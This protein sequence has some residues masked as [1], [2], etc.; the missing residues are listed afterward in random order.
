MGILEDIL[1]RHEERL[2]ITTRALLFMYFK[3]QQKEAGKTP[4]SWRPYSGVI[5]TPTTQQL[6]PLNMRRD[7]FSIVNLGPSPLICAP[8]D[9]N[10]LT[11]L[12]QIYGANYTLPVGSP[13]WSGILPYLIIEANQ[14]ATTINT[15]GP[16]YA[17][18]ANSTGAS[19]N[20]CEIHIIESEYDAIE[21]N[22]SRSMAANGEAG[23]L[24]RGHDQG[25]D[26]S[27][28]KATLL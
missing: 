28:H 11:A 16:F 15:S 5:N 14:S 2:D 25:D 18:V 6:L 13:Q 1:A 22:E 12:Q 26:K 23:R 20:T 3:E 24:N 17:Y 21:I 27:A 19:N 9:F 10:G 4:R 8:M 7:A